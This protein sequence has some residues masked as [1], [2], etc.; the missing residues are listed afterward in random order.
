MVELLPGSDDCRG[1]IER[2][3]GFKISR[4]ANYELQLIK[5]GKDDKSFSSEKIKI[6][7]EDTIKVDCLAQG[8]FAGVIKRIK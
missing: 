4:L 7:K 6:R 2:C 8:G 5:D 3:H 1:R